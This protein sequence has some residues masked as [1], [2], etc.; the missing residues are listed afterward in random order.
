VTAARWLARAAAALA[1]FARGFVGI[2]AHASHCASADDA[3][4][5]L[6]DAAERRGRC[7]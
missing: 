5:A 1:A 6:G 3:R 4:A 2:P 7:C